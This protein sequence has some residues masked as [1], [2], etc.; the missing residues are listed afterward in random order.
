MKLL[1]SSNIIGQEVISEDANNLVAPDCLQAL[2][3][4]V[5]LRCA[6]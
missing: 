4:K 6:A 5:L 2:E 3:V 1:L